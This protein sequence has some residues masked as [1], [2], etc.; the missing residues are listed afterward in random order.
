MSRRQDTIR[1]ANRK[2][3]LLLRNEY[4]DDESW[5]IGGVY[6]ILE[7]HPR[8]ARIRNKHG[9]LPLHVF[10]DLNQNTILDVAVVKAL[11]Q[12]YPESVKKEDSDRYTPLHLACLYPWTEP[13]V[14]FL[15]EEYPRALSIRNNQGNTP[16]EDMLS[17]VFS[18]EHDSEPNF[19]FN[20]I[21]LSI[22]E[23][24]FEV[25]PESAKVAINYCQRCKW[26][27]H[28]FSLE[29]TVPNEHNVV[30]FHH[31]IEY[32]QKREALVGGGSV[33]LERT[34]ESHF[35]AVRRCRY[36]SGSFRHNNVPPLCSND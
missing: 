31:I 23:F 19:L 26:P 9:M 34:V 16:L 2:L 24:L 25:C 29:F 30:S 36:S 6:R 14:R 35:R 17:T 4:W 28:G 1:K 7:K 8:V 33:A 10:L 13:I 18:F 27:C 12:V 21:F 20:P 11:V 22:L 3:N 15:L 5:N 32:K